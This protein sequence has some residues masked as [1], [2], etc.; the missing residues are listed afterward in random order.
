MKTLL[1]SSFVVLALGALT[2]AC[3]EDDPSSTGT[4]ASSSSSSSGASSSSSSSSS[5]GAS[6]SSSGGASSGGG[7]TSS[8]GSSATPS[9]CASAGAAIC[10]RACA[11]ATD[12]K[13]H[14]GIDT[15]NG[16]YGA[17]NYD[18]EAKCRDFYV[19]LACVNGGEAGFDY[20]TCEA[21]VKAAA[22]VDSAA[23]KAGLFPT[24]C[25]VTK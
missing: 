11:C 24:E 6:S 8:S 23:G 14:V 4:P 7:N 25:K 20:A 13:C 5:G 19:D 3:G 12:G 15:G 21:K 22:C 16:T 2:F 1:A 9:A 10:A 17:V 18:D